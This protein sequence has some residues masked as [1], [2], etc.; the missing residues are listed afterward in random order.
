[1]TPQRP[2]SRERRSEGAGDRRA[3]GGLR[4]GGPK[5]GAEFAAKDGAPRDELNTHGQPRTRAAR[6]LQDLMEAGIGLE[7]QSNLEGPD[8]GNAASKVHVDEHTPLMGIVKADKPYSFFGHRT[9][10]WGMDVW[11][12]RDAFRIALERYME[13][14]NK[15]QQEVADLIGVSRDHLRNCLYRK[16]KRL[17]IDAIQKAAA[18]FGSQTREFIDDAA[19]PIPGIEDENTQD[20]SPARRAA[21]LRMYQ[22]LKRKDITDADVD[23]GFDLVETLWKSG[24]I[25]KPEF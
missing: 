2:Q 11:P 13:E 19:S 5:V 21:L 7:P 9:D 4:A 10:H 24:K 8:V 3:L 18:L 23:Q 12:Q 6:S 22:N 25:R 16:S 17:G 15:N 14:N 1:M 20:L